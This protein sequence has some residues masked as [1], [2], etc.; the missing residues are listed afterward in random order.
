[1]DR[2]KPFVIFRK[3]GFYND[4]IQY[5]NS[6]NF[7]KN[8]DI[9]VYVDET[10]ELDKN[11]YNIELIESDLS[12]TVQ[13]RKQIYEKLEGND[14]AVICDTYF[15]LNEPIDFSKF[16]DT[17]FMLLDTKIDDI[18]LP[19]IF[20][21]NKC[22]N[23]DFETFNQLTYFDH[24]DNIYGRAQ[25]HD[26]LLDTLVDDESNDINS[27]LF[28]FC[29]GGDDKFLDDDEYTFNDPDD[30]IFPRLIKLFKSDEL[31]Y[32]DE[33]INVAQ[34]V[35]SESHEYI[36]TY[37]I[38]D[39]SLNEQ[40]L[41]DNF[42]IA[43]LTTDK[44]TQNVLYYM[45]DI[46]KLITKYIRYFEKYYKSTFMIN[47]PNW[48]DKSLIPDELH[49]KYLTTIHVN[50][51]ILQ[52]NDSLV[53]D[54]EKYLINNKEIQKINNNFVFDNEEY[55]IFSPLRYN[56]KN[57]VATS[58]KPFK[59]H[60]I[61]DDKLI[62]IFDTQKNINEGTLFG[63]IIKFMTNYIGL[64]KIRD[65]CY[66]FQ[67]FHDKSLEP[68]G[69]SEKFKINNPIGLSCI[70]NEL[71]VLTKESNITYK[72]KVDLVK[73][74]TD[75]CP[76]HDIDSVF[77]I[78]VKI[79]NN[80][81]LS[82]KD[83]NNILSDFSGLR[84]NYDDESCANVHYDYENKIIKYNDKLHYINKFVYM[85]TNVD[86][87]D[88]KHTVCFYGDC[89]ILNPLRDK[90]NE[91]SVNI[92][93]DFKS[94]KYCFIMQ[95]NFERLS[96]LELSEI[97]DHD[98]I[99]VSVLTEEQLKSN[100]FIKKFT[101][102]KILQKLYLFNIGMNDNYIQFI[103]DKIIMDDQY[104]KRKQFMNIDRQNMFNSSNIYQIIKQ[105]KEGK[106]EK[107]IEETNKSL[108]NKIKKN[109]FDNDSSFNNLINFIINKE[110][111]IEIRH[112]NTSI[113]ESLKKLNLF[114]SN[115]SINED[116]SKFDV[117]VL[118]NINELKNVEVSNN[119]VFFY[120]N[121]TNKILMT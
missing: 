47:L 2:I 79:K 71:Y 37:F 56:N 96:N 41:I 4:L 119:E 74:F 101:A 76:I 114:G 113:P 90:F 103:I 111:D 31:L 46:D 35:M 23:A 99:I 120:I 106:Y 97:I 24:E 60:C 102:D 77:N 36:S 30:I 88:K 110:F 57:L 72:C 16:T 15:K 12:D 49:D 58:Y 100:N 85:P 26:N 108:A 82:I 98:T 70:N 28:R 53:L 42:L 92:G 1:M 84:F 7:S 91:I 5:F 68:K 21:Y 73:Y 67:V 115:K 61:K 59:V 107:K 118:S 29:F 20:C 17:T 63:N 40:K 95:N 105:I 9:I 43:G 62:Q 64:V 121:D 78:D 69:S 45:G 27:I 6:N 89:S 38:F 34:Q 52:S 39:K 25:T 86:K 8:L 66:K 14:L 19:Y 50:K 18:C 80:I 75:I 109:F 11:E 10:F 112:L 55:P 81:L 117:V 104:D 65:N 54:F 13:I 93:D 33:D 116:C 44:P 3:D 32:D 22:D 87:S 94:S 48:I 83:Y 51:E